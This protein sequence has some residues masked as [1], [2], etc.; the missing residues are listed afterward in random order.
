MIHEEFFPTLLKQCGIFATFQ[1][2]KCLFEK[3][4]GITVG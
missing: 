3:V 1:K 4:L 2:D